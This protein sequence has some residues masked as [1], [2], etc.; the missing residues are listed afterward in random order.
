MEDK[1]KEREIKNRKEY[2]KPKLKANKNLSWNE[3]NTFHEKYKK[4]W[5]YE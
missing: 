2:G 3:K 5:N 1:K 4:D